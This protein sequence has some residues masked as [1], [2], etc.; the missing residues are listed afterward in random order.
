VRREIDWIGVPLK[1]DTLLLGIWSGAQMLA[2]HLRSPRPPPPPRASEGRLL[3]DPSDG[4]RASHLRLQV[5]QPRLPNGT[6]KGS[7]CHAEQLLSP[8]ADFEARPSDI[9]GRPMTPIPSGS[10]FCNYVPLVALTR[11][12]LA[13]PGARPAIAKSKVVPARPRRGAHGPALFCVAAPPAASRVRFPNTLRSHQLQD[14]AG[15]VSGSRREPEPEI[16]ELTQPMPRSAFTASDMR[17]Y[18]ADQRLRQLK[19]LGY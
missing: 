3:S 13:E 18:V 1:E 19:F 5:P 16:G 8:G 2:R 9:A 12:R 6:G 7:I 4:T 10:E 17:R 14:R 11:E 15:S